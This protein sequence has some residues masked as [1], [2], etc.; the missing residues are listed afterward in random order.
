MKVQAE[1]GKVP[2]DSDAVAFT[3]VPFN[4]NSDD[5]EHSRML[6][7]FV[8]GLRF[9]DLPESVIDRA[10]K[11]F[12]DWFA[13]A[14]AGRGARPVEILEKFAA[15]MGPAD[16]PCEILVSRRRTSAYFAALV[17]GAASHIIELDDIHGGAI[18]HP[19]V[20]VFPAVFAAA[21]ERN[22]S[23]REFLTAV[24]AAYE[25]T[26]RVGEFLGPT[27]YK[28][29]HVTGTAGT[30]GAAAGVSRLLGLDTRKTQHAFG[31]AGTQAAGLWEFLRDAA[32]SKPLH[33]GMAAS[34]GLMSAYLAKDGFTGAT[35][36]LEGAKGMSAGMSGTG[37][38]AKLSN[39]LGTR[40]AILESAFKVHSCCGHTHPAADALLEVMRREKLSAERI[41]RVTAHVHGPAME[42]LGGITK[43][44]TLHQ[45][46]F[47]MNFVLALI[48]LY[49]RA[50]LGEFTESALSDPRIG[51]FLERVDMVFDPQIDNASGN[52]WGGYVVVE[53]VD[54]RRLEG[55]VVVPKGQP[56]DTLKRDEVEAKLMQL[57]AY[58]SGATNYELKR[59]VE[60]AWQLP[61]QRD[62]SNFVLTPKPSAIV[63][64]RS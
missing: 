12:V 48:A 13:C 27:H 55:R 6:A 64:S 58:A 60:A 23:G 43:P 16:G 20:A 11:A 45:A 47:S 53:T 15:N 61:S 3:E 44:E 33:A 17:N 31:S 19:G 46:K 5:A 57:G 21:L 24:V 34:K 36:I 50:G 40:W 1:N 28:F 35:R 26:I 59:F 4:G 10:Q 41:K 39:G 2:T 30:V 18:L 7:E 51:E 25:T 14:L 49:G 32:D 29:F 22:A 63:E 42:V 37:Q 38:P 8:S 52:R 9:G 56:E 62:L 54:G